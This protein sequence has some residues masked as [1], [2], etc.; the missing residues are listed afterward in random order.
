MSEQTL[1]TACDFRSFLRSVEAFYETKNTAPHAAPST[2]LDASSASHPPNDAAATIYHDDSSATSATSPANVE[3]MPA[4]PSND[5]DTSTPTHA[6]TLAHMSPQEANVSFK[7][8]QEDEIK[9]NSSE[10]L[11]ALSG[12]GTYRDVADDRT[13]AKV[14]YRYSREFLIHFR[15]HGVSPSTLGGITA[16]IQ[17]AAAMRSPPQAQA[18]GAGDESRDPEVTWHADDSFARESHSRT[19]FLSRSIR[20][21]RSTGSATG[22]LS[23]SVFSFRRE[24]LGPPPDLS[25]ADSGSPVNF[26][27]FNSRTCSTL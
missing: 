24:P 16:A 27:F 25:R 1:A 18:P 3:D 21:H 23:G 6:Q 10:P 20:A 7:R 26:G 15:S 12:G 8:Y 4:E 19:N 11:T 14:I 13:N 2:P 9:S 17:Q 5:P 22:A